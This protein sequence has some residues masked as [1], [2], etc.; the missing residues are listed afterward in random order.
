MKKGIIVSI[1]LIGLGFVI[2]WLH[3]AA[4]IEFLEINFWVLGIISIALGII[5]IL[6]YTIVPLLEDRAKKLG[7]FKK[8]QFN[9]SKN[10]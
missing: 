8:K 10:A 4:D 3:F 6:W 5:G 9:K 2:E 1:A 7:T